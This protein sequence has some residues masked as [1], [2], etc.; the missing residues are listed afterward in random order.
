MKLFAWVQA[1]PAPRLDLVLEIGRQFRS[2][3]AAIDPLELTGPVRDDG[4]LGVVLV[5]QHRHGGARYTFRRDPE[6]VV[7]VLVVDVGACLVGGAW[8]PVGEPTCLRRHAEREELLLGLSIELGLAGNDHA[9]P[10]VLVGDAGNTS[11]AGAIGNAHAGR[12]LHGIWIDRAL[13]RRI[14]CSDSGRTKGVRGQHPALGGDASE[15]HHRLAVPLSH[16]DLLARA[17]LLHADFRQSEALRR[18]RLGQRRDEERD[19]DR[20][21]GV[22]GVMHVGDVRLGLRMVTR[23]SVAGA[24]VNPRIHSTDTG[25]EGPIAQA[26]CDGSASQFDRIPTN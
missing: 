24:S 12:D 15:R 25:K 1:L 11:E 13:K 8:L 19:D 14:E 9:R 5:R 23:N 22:D 4:A 3:C 16:R 10:L 7:A 17:I 26:P 20:D 18:G 21:S 2:N 6:D